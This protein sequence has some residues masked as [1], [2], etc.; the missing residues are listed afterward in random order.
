MTDSPNLALP[1][2]AA[3]QAQKHVT[4]NDALRL[5]DALVHLSAVSRTTVAP[6]ANAA[7]G[8]R[9]LVP[10]APTG[11]FAGQAGKLAFSEDGF[12]R[13]LT[14]KRG[15]RLY[16]ED[17]T[18]MLVFDGAL[19]RDLGGVLGRADDLA[20]LGIGTASDAVNVLAAKLNDALFA[21]RTVGEGGTG[22]L[23]L[24]F[25]K[26]SASRTASQLWQT[27]YSGR[28]ELGL[29][30]SDDFT[31]KVSA[32]GSA[33]TDALRVARASGHVLKPAMPCF[34]AVG[35]I[36]P[37]GVPGALRYQSAPLNAGSHF[38]AST[39]RFTVPTAGRYLFQ[40]AAVKQGAAAT[41]TSLRRNGSAVN[42][43]FAYVD[44]TGTNLPL[45]GVMI[46]DCAAGDTVEHWL[47]AGALLYA[48]DL[49][50]FA[51]VLLG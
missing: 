33:W 44:G 6:P 40:V 38:V 29:T 27:G 4:V 47:E 20:G 13:F 8:A 19:W 16:V 7:N 36:A 26:E 43:R 15:W 18:R 22:D 1:Y 46:L 50:T 42:G 41:W 48:A 34:N 51:G 14:P 10:V 35:A 24:K 25:N 32:T 5:A 49:S 12:W 28:A 23:R 37:T 9:Y 17:E 2:L 30:G 21:A 3:G 11:A 39:G 45:G 31:L